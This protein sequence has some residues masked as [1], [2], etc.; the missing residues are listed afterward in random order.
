MAS[1]IPNIAMLKEAELIIPIDDQIQVYATIMQLST[2]SIAYQAPELL[3]YADEKIIKW[4]ALLSTHKNDEDFPKTFTIGEATLKYETVM[5]WVEILKKRSGSEATHVK[6][7]R[8]SILEPD[9]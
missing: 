6:I 7:E 3:H 4:G 5:K 9:D 1:S 8:V 2:H